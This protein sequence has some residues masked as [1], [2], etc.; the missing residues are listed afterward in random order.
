[1]AIA[2]VTGAS[3]GLGEEFAWQLA[4]AGHDVVLVARSR[5]RLSEVAHLLEGATGRHAEILEADLTTEKGRSAVAARLQADERPVSLLVNNAGFGLGEPFTESTWK[6]EKALL[7]IHVT[8]PLRL[9]HAAI[10]GMVERGH[11]AVLSV[12]SVAAHLANST[13][14]AHKRW[15][16]D[17]TQA[18]AGQLEGTG[19]TATAVLPGLVRTRFHDADTLRHMRDDFPDAVWLDPE[20]VVASALAAVRRGQTVVTPSP[21]YAVAGAVLRAVPRRLTRGRR[22]QQRD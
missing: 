17:F 19:V 8:A 7:D 13:Y 14:A 21:G 2:L 20:R 22:S 6:R 18:L 12:S 4:T 9:A 16:V 15:A 11:G 10:P 3:A 1:M 5:D